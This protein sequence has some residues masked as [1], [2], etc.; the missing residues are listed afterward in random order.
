M[1]RRFLVVANEGAGSAGGGG[2]SDAVLELAS[3]GAVRMVWTKSAQDVVRAATE[4]PDA[5]LIAAGGDG[6]LMGAVDAVITNG[7]SD[8]PLGLLPGGTGNDFLRG[9]GAPMDLGAAARELIRAVPRRM[10]ALEVGGRHGINALHIGVGAAASRRAGQFKSTL[11]AAAYPLGAV[12]AGATVDPW[13]VEVIDLSGRTLFCGPSLMVAV[14]LGRSIG[15][16]TV[17][18][19]T[20]SP[21]DARASVLVTTHDGWT[22]RLAL[23]RA[24]VSGDPARRDVAERFEAS[25]VHLRS[26]R[27]FPVNLDGED[28]GDQTE[29]TVSV[30][31]DAWTALLPVATPDEG[32]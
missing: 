11:K 25:K 22:G 14:V 21:N 4:D 12:M 18:A 17:L 8:R 26:D 19:P 27:P 6:T 7:M 15:G 5:V 31:P 1:D 24:L 20:G 28:L 16:G 13:E 23:S 9:L 30:V 32:L 10:S 3:E 29:L 2:L